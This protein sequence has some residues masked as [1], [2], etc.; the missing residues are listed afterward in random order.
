MIHLPVVILAG[1]L[2][3]RIASVAGDKPKA[4]LTLAG[5]P[6]IRW[7]LDEL[8]GQGIKKIYLLL[9]YGADQIVGYLNKNDFPAEI[10][11][12]RDEPNCTGT[13]QAINNSFKY[14]KEDQFILT[15][16]DNLLPIEIAEFTYPLNDN[17]CRMVTTTNIGPSDKANAQV[18]AGHVIAYGKNQSTK[19]HELDY[20][21]S[22]ISKS[23]LAAYLNEESTDLAPAFSQ[24]AKA[25]LL[26]AYSTDLP[27]T[28]IGTP[29]TYFLADEQLRNYLQ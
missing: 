28:E 21:Y 23:C 14:I 12:V 11:I 15:Y 16:G 9:G 1:G 29:T 13:G 26:E 18:Q 24:I 17:Y 22:V 3:T 2:G 7:K 4:L 25:G 19:Y 8:I 20:G 6:F 5:T 10:I 27:Y